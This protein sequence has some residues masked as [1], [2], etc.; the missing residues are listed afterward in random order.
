MSSTLV[1]RIVKYFDDQIGILGSGKLPKIKSEIGSMRTWLVKHQDE[2]IPE[3]A[4]GKIL[5]ILEKYNRA[6]T[7]HLASIRGPVIQLYGDYLALP[8]G[9]LCGTKEKNRVLNWYELLSAVEDAPA[10]SA[11]SGAAAEATAR[12]TRWSVQGVEAASRQVTLLN[13]ED[14][15]LWIEDLAVGDAELFA[16]IC[17]RYEGGEGGD[18]GQGDVKVQFDEAARQV[19]AV[20]EP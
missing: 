19:V 18:G 9:K 7:G 1:D 12:I 2:S 8:E 11:A 20:L 17:A 6:A 16:A 5:S 4:K 10:T 13:D 15:D 14:A 3:G